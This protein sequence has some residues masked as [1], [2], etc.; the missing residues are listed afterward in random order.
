MPG[1]AK[2]VLVIDDDVALARL[3]Q[4]ELERHRYK[5][6]I[7]ASG[8]AGLTRVAEGGVDVVI[9]DHHLPDQD[10]LDVLAAIGQL[11]EAPPVIYLTASAGAFLAVAAL[12]AGAAD[13]VV[14]DVSGD[15]R[16]LL[17]HALG[18]AV[19]AA[20]AQ[21]A[22]ETAEAEVRAA[23]DRFKALAEERAL[24]MREVNHRVGNGLAFAVSLLRM[25]ASRAQDPEVSAA[26]SD[27]EARIQAVVRV[28]RHLYTSDDI[29]SV[30]LDLYLKSLIDDLRQSIEE[31]G[32]ELT[33]DADPVEIDP[34]RAVAAG[35]LV[36]ELVINAKK[37][38][39]PGSKGQI[40][41]GLRAIDAHSAELSVQDDGIGSA[42]GA[43]SAPEGLGTM[44]IQAMGFKLGGKIVFD[45]SHKG[46]RVMLTFARGGHGPS[47]GAPV[48]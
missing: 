26:L 3:L 35:V 36:T 13:Y 15:F 8:T 5:V 30:S 25:H 7:A 18:S 42:N 20:T 27:A 19:A 47:E 41:V 38:A 4:T 24:L 37:H 17:L 29:R 21:R 2:H 22:K 28:H 40:R 32:A 46:M 34:D 23:R 43:S 39:Y 31:T 16:T 1:G 6:S 48:G 33:V 44:I 45:P 14:K 11:P 12:R 9:L 10:G